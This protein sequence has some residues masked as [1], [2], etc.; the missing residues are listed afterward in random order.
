MVLRQL[1]LYAFLY[2]TAVSI[3]QQPAGFHV[4]QYG[5]EDG[6][7]SNGIKGLQ[8]DKQTGFLWIATEAGMVR[9]NGMDFKTYTSEDNPQITN[10]RILFLIRNN[11]G[12]I[13]TADNTGNIFSV[14][15]NSLSFFAS[16]PIS[17]NSWSNI[18]TLVVS[19]LF[20]N[21]DHKITNGPFALQFDRVLPQSDTSCFILHGG[22][23]Y[24]FS[25]SM[26]L[27]ALLPSPGGAITTAFKCGN[28]FF[29]ADN[30]NNFYRIEKTSH[31]FSPIEL[32]ISGAAAR[33]VRKN[34]LLWE[35]GMENPI[36]F[37]ESNAWEIIF[38]NGK[39]NAEMI[40]NQV[41][42]NALIRY[43]QYDRHSKSFFIGTD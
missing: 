37:S 1:F 41:P 16:K 15:K 14:N 12:T 33:D 5:T 3:A 18:L 11:A 20:Y 29:L 38:D 23:L 19:D 27:P 9:Y 7:P 2:C 28:E 34:P 4:K 25:L 10:E 32:T 22:Q 30:Q 42:Q 13:Y 43:A 39:L 8:W 31:R 6:L 24:Y 26:K 21:A 17:G 35:N 36:L 40:C